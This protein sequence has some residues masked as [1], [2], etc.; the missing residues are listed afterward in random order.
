MSDADDFREYKLYRHSTSGF[1]E[2]TGELLHISTFRNDTSFTDSIPHSST[3]YYRL[4]QMN[5]YGRLGGSNIVKISSGVYSNNEPLLIMEEINERYLNKAEIMWLY[6]PAVKGE[7]YK[8][9]WDHPD[10]SSFSAN[11][12]CYRENKSDAYFLNEINVIHT[13]SPRTIIA[14]E[15]ENIYLRYI[16]Q[17]TNM[18]GEFRLLVQHL[19][20]ED[21]QE[22]VFDTTY[23]IPIKL[24][25]T[26][27]YYFNA[28]ANSQYTINLTAEIDFPA[29]VV[30][31]T[32]FRE[33]INYT[34]F[35]E[36]IVWSE[37]PPSHLNFTSLF[38]EPIYIVLTGAFWLED[39]SIGLDITSSQ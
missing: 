24:S 29:A 22:I 31:A 3:Y 23:H 12:S 19:S 33:K 4:Y 37:Y 15:S 14:E 35:K 9:T 26:R 11:V 36:E 7:I 32:V 25:E 6:F 18:E 21:A 16:G 34:F 13:G 2:S 39:A 5:E 17:T 1:D 27:L 28:N 8:I 30:K 38:T 20:Y 10:W